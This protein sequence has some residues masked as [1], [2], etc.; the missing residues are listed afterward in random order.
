MAVPFLLNIE[1]IPA[2]TFQ[3]FVAA[4]VYS[5][6][7]GDLLGAMHLLV[8]TLLTISVVQGTFRLQPLRLVTLIAVSLGLTLAVMEGTHLYLERAL[9][10]TYNK[11]QVVEKMSLLLNPSPAVVHRSVPTEPR[12][13]RTPANGLQAILQSRTLRVGYQ[14]DHKPFSFFNAKGELVGF[15]VDFAHLLARELSVRLDSES[16]SELALE[17]VPFRWD[18]LARQLNQ[19]D[20]DVA[21]S[22]VPMTTTNLRRMSFSSSYLD[23]TLA[24]VVLDWR[25]REFSR[26]ETVQSMDEVRLAVPESKSSYLI[27][28][29]TE[30]LPR[31]TF[32]RIGS[33]DDILGEAHSPVD[34][35]LTTAEAGSV[36][37]L[38]HPEYA[39]VVPQPNVVKIPVGYAVARGNPD[40]VDFLSHWIELKSKGGEIAE[41]YD[42]WILGKTAEERRRRWSIAQDVLHWVD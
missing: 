4:G 12:S 7:L 31:A 11:D 34:A 17:F 33:M 40:L 36:W 18:S 23:L 32:V 25:R 14:L 13:P 19:N 30:V 41:L 26:Y 39:V 8:L 37:T 28:A 21:M 1:H 10:G 5:T 35:V 24:F 38:L 20:F 9:A 15:D 22:G 42:H 27:G 3:L 6:R 29:L 16:E 2:D